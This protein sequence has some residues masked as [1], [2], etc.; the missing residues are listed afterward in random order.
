[1]KT[2]PKILP[3]IQ[4]WVD[5]RET[6]LIQ[7]LK[8]RKDQLGDEFTLQWETQQHD[9]GD[10]LFTYGEIPLVFIERKTLDDLI[11]SIR[12]GRYREQKSRF[13]NSS[14]LQKYYLLEGRLYGKNI[15]AAELVN[16]GDLWKAEDQLYENKFTAKDMKTIRGAMINTTIRD[17]IPMLRSENIHDTLVILETIYHSIVEHGKVIISNSHAKEAV[18]PSF[19]ESMKTTKKSQMTPETC[20]IRQIMIIPGASLAI[21]QMICETY[22]NYPQLIQSYSQLASDKEKENMLAP[23]VLPTGRKIGPVVS[24]RIYDFLYMTSVEKI[25]TSIKSDLRSS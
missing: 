6:Y 25:D 16:Y 1:M 13:K 10:I 22:N 5:T 20:F 2:I 17:R 7:L 24:K 19:L 9:L 8:Q 18:M 4:M 21:A 23:L 3:K 12:D 14:Y 15:S 11:G